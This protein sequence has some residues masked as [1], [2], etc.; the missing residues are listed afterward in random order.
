MSGFTFDKFNALASESLGSPAVDV[1]CESAH[2]VRRRRAI[3]GRGQ[4]TVDDGDALGTGGADDEYE[5]LR[6]RSHKPELSSES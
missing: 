4:E 3:R 1:T 2:D 6:S 5:F